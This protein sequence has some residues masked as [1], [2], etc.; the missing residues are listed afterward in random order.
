MR[1]SA[2][3]RAVSKLALD[4]PESPGPRVLLLPA[5]L[6]SPCACSAGDTDLHEQHCPHSSASVTIRFPAVRLCFN[7]LTC[8]AQK[9]NRS[10]S[11][12]N[13]Y[14]TLWTVDRLVTG[15]WHSQIAQ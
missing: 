7:L 8:R 9:Q 5:P 15:T 13:V 1:L 4:T 12:E 2:S 10:I 14:C 11:G 6:L 3:S